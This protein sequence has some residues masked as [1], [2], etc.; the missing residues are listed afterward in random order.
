MVPAGNL[1]P[2]RSGNRCKSLRRRPEAFTRKK[3]MLN[4]GT[5]QLFQLGIGEVVVKSSARVLTRDLDSAHTLII[6]GQG[7][8]DMRRA[9]DGK[10]MFRTFD[11][12][13]SF[14]GAE[15]DLDHDMLLRH[16][17]QQIL[18]S[19]L[20]HYINAVADSLRMRYFN[21]LPDVEAQALGWNQGRCQFTCVKADVDCGIDRV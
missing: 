11:S 7:Y 10:R 14:V 18:G 13:D 6:G 4:S 19:V 5:R 3:A 2:A 15:V 12:Q 8:R 9:I 21:S 17:P 1:A 20:V 16:L